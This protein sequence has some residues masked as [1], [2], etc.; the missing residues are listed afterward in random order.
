VKPD[1]Q[2]RQPEA[3]FSGPL[4]KKTSFF[5]DFERRSID[6]NAVI[7]AV[8]LDPTYNIVPFSQ[9]IVIPVTSLEANVKIDRQLSTNHSL[10]F[11][12]HGPH[13]A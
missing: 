12:Y 6:D 7:S 8:F 11:R 2:K 13:S 5:F 1:Y 4:G 10:A 3:E 9:A